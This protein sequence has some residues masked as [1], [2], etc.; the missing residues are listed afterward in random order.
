MKLVSLDGKNVMYWDHNPTDEWKEVSFKILQDI[1]QENPDAFPLTV[2]MPIKDKVGVFPIPFEHE[3]EKIH[4][5]GII[6]TM[7][8][9]V[10]A[11]WYV[12]ASECWFVMRKIEEVDDSIRPSQCD[13]RKECLMVLKVDKK[14]V[15][16]SVLFEITRDNGITTFT[17]NKNLR[18]GSGRLSE[19]FDAEISQDAL[20][21]MKRHMKENGIL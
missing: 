16:S 17:E 10:K 6:S 15:D 3:E 12:I 19:L 21:E 1:F 13:D 9:V 11:E 14:G 20:I 18:F 5:L 7:L 8:Q 2:V 4:R